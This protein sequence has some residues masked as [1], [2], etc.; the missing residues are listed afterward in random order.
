MALLVIVYYAV[1][2]LLQT[3]DK[4]LVQ[5]ESIK[6]E[7]PAEEKKNS[8]DSIIDDKNIALT[9]T[10][11]E[12]KISGKSKS[13][14]DSKSVTLEEDK[15]SSSGA[16]APSIAKVKEK[17]SEAVAERKVADLVEE[18]PCSLRKLK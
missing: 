6:N 16:A 7:E 1:T 2:P 11:R 5:S 14:K 13:K 10:K 4:K 3:E 8:I 18:K 9:E 12:S 15:I 17:E